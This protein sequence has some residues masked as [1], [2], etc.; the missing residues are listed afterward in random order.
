M[1]TWRPHQGRGEDARKRFALL[2]GWKPVL[3]DGREKLFYDMGAGYKEG[4]TKRRGLQL[5]E[6]RQE[7]EL[8][9]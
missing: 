7:K 6:L 9:Y 4:H 1:V 3:K 8:L 5:R 2:V